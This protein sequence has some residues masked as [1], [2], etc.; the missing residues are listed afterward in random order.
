MSDCPRNVLIRGARNGST[1]V[2]G[3]QLKCVGVANPPPSYR[4]TNA[5]DNTTVEGDTFT[6][7]AMKDYNLT[8]TTTTDITYASGRK[9]TCSS[10]VYFEVNGI[11]KGTIKSFYLYIIYIIRTQLELRIL[12]LS[13]SVTFIVTF[14]RLL[15]CYIFYSKVCLQH[16]QLGLQDCLLYKVVQRQNQ[17]VVTVFILRFG[18]DICCLTCQKIIKIGQQLP[19]LQ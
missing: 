8:C 11:H 13:V 9:E 16:R 4:W 6:V 12:I 19:K 14:A 17:G 2:E 15:P 7:G 5:V 10:R 1:V 3:T 18:T